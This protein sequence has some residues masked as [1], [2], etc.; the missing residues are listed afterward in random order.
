MGTPALV[1]LTFD[2]GM[3]CQF[4]RAVP[5]LD[6]HGLA[7]TFFL[8]ANTSPIFM[9]GYA[10][11]FKWPKIDWSEGDRQFL[12]GMVQRGHEIGSHSVNHKNDFTGEQAKFEPE[13]LERKAKFEAERS[14]RL[15]EEWIGSEIAS[16]C[17][18]FCRR[19]AVL[20]N[21]VIA[22]GYRQAR[23]GANASYYSLPDHPMD[24]FDVDCRQITENENVNGWVRS[25]CWHILMIHGIGTW[26]DG[27]A[28]VTVDQFALQMAEL[29]KHRDTGTVEVVTFKNGADRI[30]G[31]R[32]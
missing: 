23:A 22:A 27:W 31:H 10:D 19:P 15:I 4:E 7:A 3:R 32:N 1:S 11:H 8:V 5:I 16:F 29:A 14:K 13:E 20:K 2:D 17:Y 12:K 9:D 24:W 28:P 25:G 30:R 6:Q 18:P 21:A 26:N